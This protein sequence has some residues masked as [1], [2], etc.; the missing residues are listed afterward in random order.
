MTSSNSPTGTKP[1]TIIGILLSLMLSIS[2]YCIIKSFSTDLRSADNVI[3]RCKSG[4]V[5][6]QPD[7]VRTVDSK[8]S[9][10]F[11]GCLSKYSTYISQMYM[12]GKDL[13][14]SL[15][16]L[17]V[18]VFVGSI[19]FSEKI[20]V[21]SKARPGT[22]FLMILSWILLLVSIMTCGAAV[23]YLVFAYG[24]SAPTPVSVFASS[25][26]APKGGDV[27][28]IFTDFNVRE[29]DDFVTDGVLL[30]ITSGIAFALSL[31]LMLC[32]GWRSLSTNGTYY[33]QSSA[34]PPAPSR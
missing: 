18:A 19:A 23:C 9:A 33:T 27:A 25:A 20:V 28:A 32:A 4:G 10:T 6:Y 22:R 11:Q 17:A 12:E 26:T 15:L 8:D 21:W 13:A 7:H 31:I 24:G 16:P 2:A 14:K 34:A 29:V 5:E 3:E 1:I 30:G